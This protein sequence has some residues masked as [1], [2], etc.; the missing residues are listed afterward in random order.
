MTAVTLI[1]A[2]WPNQ[3]DGI[4]WCDLPWALRDAGLPGQLHDAGHTVVESVLMSESDP[5]DDLRAGFDLAWQIGDQVRQ[6]R[7]GGEL[8]VI[9]C[10]SCSVAACGALAGIADADCGVVWFDAHADLNTPETTDSGLFEGMALAVATGQAWRTMA[11]TRGGLVPA[12]LGNVVLAG[13]R[14]FDPAETAL[15]EAERVAMVETREV[16]AD[17]LNPRHPLYV[18]LDMDVHDGAQCRANAYATPGGPSVSHVRGLLSGLGHAAAISVTGLDPATADMDVAAAVAIGH[19]K[20]VA[21][22]RDTT[23]ENA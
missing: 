3:P 7:A 14:M 22:A 21:D 6:A 13:V 19:I 15:I 23:P 2:Y 9:L 5:P 10:G 17:H 18:H 4:T 8:P 20:A 1:Y 16:L 12:R 11:R